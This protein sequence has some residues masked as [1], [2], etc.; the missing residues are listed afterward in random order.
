MAYKSQDGRPEIFQIF[1]RMPQGSPRNQL[2]YG[3]KDSG[4]I[5]V[6]QPMPGS[7]LDP[8]SNE[9][10]FQDTSCVD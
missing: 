5:E 10:I 9:S 8:L 1:H 7:P 6:E 4:M 2:S 3:S